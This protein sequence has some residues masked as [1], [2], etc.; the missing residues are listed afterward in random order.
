MSQNSGFF[1]RS[2]QAFFFSL[3]HAIIRAFS[4]L[5]LAL[6]EDVVFSTVLYEKEGILVCSEIE[7]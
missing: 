1:A 5:F 2:F 6:P 3:T 7:A 4:G